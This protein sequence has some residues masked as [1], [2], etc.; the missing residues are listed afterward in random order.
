[1]AQSMTPRASVG[2][3]AANES[4]PQG[5]GDEEHVYYAIIGACAA[6]LSVALVWGVFPRSPFTQS[7]LPATSSSPYHVRHASAGLIKCLKSRSP[8]TDGKPV[9]WEDGAGKTRN[10]TAPHP[11]SYGVEVSQVREVDA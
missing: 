10:A 7:F 8:V 4:A 11:V 9:A 3:N 1:M 6:Y 2:A 5:H